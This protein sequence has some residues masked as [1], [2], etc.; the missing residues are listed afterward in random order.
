ML[1]FLSL[2]IVVFILVLV[3]I[4]WIICRSCPK[5]KGWLL[6]IW[7][8]IFWNT[9]IRAVLESSLGI[10]LGSMIK[11]GLLSTDG[12]LQIFYSILTIAQITLI[13]VLAITIPI[14]LYFKNNVLEEKAFIDKYGTLIMNMHRRDYGHKLY[15]TFF[16]ARRLILAALIIYCI[17][18]PNV[19][20]MVITFSTSI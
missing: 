9:I 10:L 7:R 15:Y 20:I 17:E 3:C 19:Q 8:K 11:T 18:L 2:V 16:L 12:A 14:F 13:V 5:V 4:L 1:L 6:I